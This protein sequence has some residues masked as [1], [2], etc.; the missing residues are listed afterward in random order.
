[1]RRRGVT[2]PAAFIAVE[3]SRVSATA[4]PL[5][6]IDSLA[7]AACQFA[8]HSGPLVGVSPNALLLT[9]LILRN[10][11]MAT[12]SRVLLAAVLLAGAAVGLAAWRGAG[13]SPPQPADVGGQK[14]TPT[15]PADTPARAT[16]PEERVSVGGRVV[17]ASGK[18]VR[19]AAVYLR[20]QPVSRVSSTWNP[21]ESRNL[22][23][24]T[25]DADGRFSFRDVALPPDHFGR[26]RPCRLDVLV[27]APGHALAWRHLDAISIRRP[28]EV[29]VAPEAKVQG[30]LV[31]RNGKPLAL[32]AVRLSEIARLDHEWIA[33]LGDPGY[34]DLHWSNAPLITRSDAD[35]RLRLPGL[36]A[37]VRATLTVVE[38]GY[39]R[40]DILVATTETP[41]PP[42]KL[43]ENR[44][45]RGS[46]ETA[47]VHHGDFTARVDKAFQLRAQVVFDDT[48]KPALG[49]RWV[50]PPIYAPANRDTDAMAR[51]ALNQLA[52]GRFSLRVYPPA[53]SDFLGVE[54]P[55]D[56]K[57]EPRL[58]EPTIRLPRGVMVH[59]RVLDEN[60]GK[61]L[62]AAEVEHFF[63]AEHGPAPHFAWRARTDAEGKFR[64][65]V[66]P[67]KGNLV[68]ME[69]PRGYL[70]HENRAWQR[71]ADAGPSFLRTFDA[72]DNKKLP[73]FEFLVSRGVEVRGHA[74]APDGKPVRVTRLK[75][76]DA[77][78]DR[79]VFWTA[80][81]AGELTLGGLR[82]GTRYQ[83][84]IVVPERNLGTFLDFTAPHPD[85]KPM[86][87]RINLEPMASL[88]GRVTDE[89]GMPIAKAIV[90]LYEQRANRLQGG[91]GGTL[92]RDPLPVSPDGTF[93]WKDLI[94]GVNY[95]VHADA[96]GRVHV[97]R[98]LADVAWTAEGGK[99]HHLPDLRLKPRE[100]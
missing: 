81:P 69:V 40:E 53:N 100:E 68:L 61:G 92:I 19:Q 87:L 12:L 33:P 98:L 14:P 86:P 21:S 58:L 72:S 78:P 79:Q 8:S 47:T 99:V 57:G 65:A 60:A 10:W 25:S 54:T 95:S 44:R 39:M 85:A 36:P 66:P 34:L 84:A 62:A 55:F 29:A 50:E 97:S 94:P 7:R 22:A 63:D 23:Q 52:P 59:G 1:L 18:P 45:P 3:L 4:L 51:L 42:L 13:S 30:R 32:V 75:E 26:F 77:N 76:L 24:T 64:I 27:Q 80:T 48:G 73:V 71:L 46:P 89:D 2:T 5:P 35:G 70:G 83:F 96:D 16:D 82:P 11:P 9:Q 49:A 91:T 93:L 6:F 31:D 15:K 88:G 56:L 17:D 41:Q 74:Y 28:V 67:T 38:P 90:R 20:E 43:D 37:G